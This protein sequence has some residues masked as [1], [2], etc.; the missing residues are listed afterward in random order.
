MKQFLKNFFSTSNEINE[1]TVVG[2]ALLIIFLVATFF[3]IVDQEKYY[4]LAGMTAICF[5][6]APFKK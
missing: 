1:T 5:G 6:L 4:I 3:K 2:T